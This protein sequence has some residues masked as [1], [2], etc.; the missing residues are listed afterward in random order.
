MFRWAYK[1]HFV[2]VIAYT[3]SLH[4]PTSPSKLGRQS[5]RVAFLLIWV[6]GYNSITVK[7]AGN[8]ETY[9]IRRE[10]SDLVE[11]WNHLLVLRS[12]NSNLGRSISALQPW[13]PLLVPSYGYYTCLKTM[14]RI[15]GILVWIRIRVG[16]SM[17]LTKGFGFG[18]GPHFVCKFSRQR[19]T[20]V[21]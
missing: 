15:H 4:L 8:E 13:P 9:L 1:Q 19:S 12:Q 17:P 6:S 14:L 10:A 11:V 20:Q 7:V 5:W 2:K 16:G 21:F 3:I 18:S